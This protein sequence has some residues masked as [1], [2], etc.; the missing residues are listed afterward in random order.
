MAQ[1]VGLHIC[2]NALFD[3]TWGDSTFEQNASLVPGSAGA[4]FVLQEMVDV[5][6][7]TVHHRD[8]L[9]EVAQNGL[10]TFDKHIRFR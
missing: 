7:I 2:N 6:S 3:S 8:Q 10:R 9:V 1:D 5:I 4:E